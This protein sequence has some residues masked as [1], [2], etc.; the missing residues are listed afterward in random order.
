VS[1]PVFADLV[2]QEHVIQQLE[3][4]IHSSPKDS[5]QEMSHAW[6]FTGPPGSGRSNIAKV[7]AA[8]LVCQEKGCGSCEAC[9]TALAGTHPDV[10]LVDVSGLSIK[11]DEIREIV[12]RSSWGASSSNWRVVVIEDCDRM[13]EA[14]ANALLKA[15]EEPGAS[16]IWLLCAPTLHD[17]LPTVRS[18]CRH[19]NLKTPTTSEIAGYLVEKLDVSH[20]QAKFA[21]E[22]SQGHIGKAI[23]LLRTPE[24]KDIR[25]KTFA[26]LFS[27]KSEKDAIRAAAQLIE[28]AQEQVELRTAASIEKELDEFRA[29]MQNGSKGMLSG[30]AKAI[31]D[32]ER[33]QKTRSS[34]AIKDELDGYLLDYTSLFRDCLLSEGSW[35]NSDLSTEILNYAKQLP[36]GSIKT[37][38]NNLN[39]L[40]ERL[41]TN[42]SQPLLLEAFFTSLALHS[43]GN[44]HPIL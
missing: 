22:I 37:I 13:T 3:R 38:L 23:R 44:Q 42:A 9:K 32:F 36:K 34:R 5:G 15:L 14:A 41:A 43:R 8:A 1:A 6:L 39:A 40:R 12:S 20:D 11:I 2:G 28:I 31:K 18:R 7:F 24:S 29:M 16:M 33:D 30:G 35:T 27:I 19:L 26:I 10:E 21:A 17:V 4:A 25:K